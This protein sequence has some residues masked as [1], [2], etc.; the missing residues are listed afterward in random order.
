MPTLFAPTYLHLPIHTFLF[1]PR[2]VV[3]A[4]VGT[5]IALYQM[6]FT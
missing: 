6:L 1:T 2:T 4:D 5:L 3:A